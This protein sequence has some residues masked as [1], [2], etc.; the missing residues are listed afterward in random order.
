MRSILRHL[1]PERRT[2]LVI[3][4]LLLVQA[5]CDLFLPYYTAALIDVGIVSEGVEY[6]VP[7]HIRRQAYEDVQQHMQPDERALWQAS[8]E[9][10]GEA[11]ALKPEADVQALDPVFAPPLAMQAHAARGTPLSRA[12]LDRMGEASMHKTAISLVSA[13][14]QALGINLREGQ[15]AFLLRTGGKMLVLAL[16]MAIGSVLTGFFAARVG[17]SVG[18]RLRGR[19][20]DRVM[21]FSGAELSRFSIASLITRSTGDVQQIQ[22]TATMLLRMAFYAPLMGLGGVIMVVR[23][24]GGMEWIIAVAVALL[25]ALVGLLVSG[26][27]IQREVLMLFS[28]SYG[29]IITYFFTRKDNTAN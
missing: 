27:E 18:H 8:Y 17:A 5:A 3:F 6:A 1:W 11:Y 9:A 15:T 21:R 19:V 24:G 13:E 16:A 12:D 2:V 26:A 14:Y 7:E 10:E 20:F 4:A 25:L 28:T 23:T 29:A 22:Q